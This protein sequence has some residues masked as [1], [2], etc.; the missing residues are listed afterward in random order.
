MRGHTADSAA[1]GDNSETCLQR[2][3]ANAQLLQ[4]KMHQFTAHSSAV[5]QDLRPSE[6]RQNTRSVTFCDTAD[7]KIDQLRQRYDAEVLYHLIKV[8]DLTLLVGDRKG[9]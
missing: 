8:C 3:L 9:I 2:L 5:D 1:S 7:A 6:R 4:S